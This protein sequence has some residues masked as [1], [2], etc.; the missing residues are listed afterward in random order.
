MS[1]LRLKE[2]N[3]MIDSTKDKMIYQKLQV[4]RLVKFKKIKPKEAAKSVGK[5]P[6]DIHQWLYKYEH[7][8]VEALLVKNVV[9]GEKQMLICHLKKKN[10]F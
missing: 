3:E 9:A 8:G 1:K 2:L 4:I 5:K 10:H 7:G 6:G